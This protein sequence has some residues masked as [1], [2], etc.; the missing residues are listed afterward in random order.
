MKNETKKTKNQYTRETVKGTSLKNVISY[1]NGKKSG[2][3]LVEDMKTSGAKL[4][5][6][7]I[8]DFATSLLD[9]YKNGHR[10]VNVTFWRETKDVTFTGTHV[11]KEKVKNI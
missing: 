3:K 1:P 5:G 9:M 10:E 7:Q 6:K 8:I 4:K 2:K 11:K